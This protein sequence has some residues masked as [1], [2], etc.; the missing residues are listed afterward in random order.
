MGRH[1]SILLHNSF[2][3]IMDIGSPD[4]LDYKA[5]ACSAIVIG[6]ILKS[7][8]HFKEIITDR[9]RKSSPA[10]VDGYLD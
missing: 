5:P 1:V 8:D 10:R 4:Y 2:L 6:S 9:N 3:L 7:I